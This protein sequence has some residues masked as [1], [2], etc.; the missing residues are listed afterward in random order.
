MNN[1]GLEKCASEHGVYVQCYQHSERREMLIV[2]LYVDDMLI[3]GSSVERITNFKFQMLQEFEKSDL[4]QLNYFLGIE[5]TKT[6]EGLMMH[7]SRYTLDMLN[8]FNMIHCNSANTPAEVGLKLEKDPEE[9]GVDPTEYRKMV[10]SLRYLCNTRPNISY[11][12]GL[13]S[14]YMQNPRISHLM[15]IKRI[16]R[17]LKG[18]HNFG[19]L[20]PGGESE[21]EVRINAYSDSD[22]CG[23]KSDRKSTAGYVFFLNGAPISWSSIKEPVVAL[24]SCET[25]YIAACEATC[26]AAW[27]S[28]L[29]SE[30]KIEVEGKV[31]LLVDNKSAIELTKHPASHGRRKHIETRFHYIREQVS[32]GK[33]EVVYCRSEDQIEDLL[34]KA[35]KGERFLILRKQIGVKKVEIKADL[36][37]RATK[38]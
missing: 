8:K 25:E 24:S 7:Q 4:G 36:Q 5:F 6:D 38:T 30:L 3:T 18:T 32:K 15:A 33:L 29:M 19:I 37:N 20:L 31:R 35:L 34:T 21:G 26:Q 22:W 14:R 10:G 17:Y 28:S 16:L 13:V 11:S 27:L 12:V 23:D 9:E 2:C 1:I